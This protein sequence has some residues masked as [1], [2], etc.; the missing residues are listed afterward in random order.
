MLKYGCTVV[1]DST[2]AI[3]GH[4]HPKSKPGVSHFSPLMAV[5]RSQ[6]IYVF[7][8]PI[9]HSN[10][11]VNT[12]ASSTFISITTSTAWQPNIRSVTASF[13][14]MDREKHLGEILSM[15]RI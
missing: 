7:V 1:C 14:K 4:S 8:A 10:L 12:K 6:S 15:T 13:R 5:N 11:L 9:I 2:F 3:A